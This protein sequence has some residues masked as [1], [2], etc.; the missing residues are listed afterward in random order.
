MYLTRRGTCKWAV[1]EKVAGG[2]SG[3]TGMQIPPRIVSTLISGWMT[4][5]AMKHVM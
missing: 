2:R 3:H 5:G 1:Y 4:R